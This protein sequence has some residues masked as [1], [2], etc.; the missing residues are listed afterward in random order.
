MPSAAQSFLFFVFFVGTK[1]MKLLSGNPDGFTFVFDLLIVE[2]KGN[3]LT[4]SCP[5][6]HRSA[7]GQLK[8]ITPASRAGVVKNLKGQPDGYPFWFFTFCYLYR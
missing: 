3:R 7:T 5:K 1:K 2:D 6:I 8:K 4:I